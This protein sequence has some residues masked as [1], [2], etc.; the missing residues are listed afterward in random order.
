MYSSIC[1]A[2]SPNLSSYFQGKSG[3][4]ILFA[5]GK[6]KIVT[7]YNMKKCT[8]RIPAN[9]TFKIPLSLMAFDQGIITQNTVFHWDGKKQNLVV[10]NQNQTP[11]TWLRYSVVWV[12]QLLTP[13]LGMEKI[14]N[15]LRQFNYGNQD[16]SGHPGLND[17]LTAAWLSGSLKISPEEQLNFIKALVNNSL[18]IS[19]QAMTNTK[20][21]MYLETSNLVKGQ[22]WKLYGKTGSGYHDPKDWMKHIPMKDVP[23]DGWFVGYVERNQ[24]TYLVVL[25]F[26]DL[27]NPHTTELAGGRAKKLAITLLTQM[28]IF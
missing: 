15:Y 24:E 9:S 28:G 11:Q 21:N 22:G 14:K 20:A 26:S 16:F 5:L 13:Q 12:S 7:E 27:E 23:Q 19:Q 17:G 4:F 8:E 10:W 3:C 18:P 25:D 1:L 2:N 6:N